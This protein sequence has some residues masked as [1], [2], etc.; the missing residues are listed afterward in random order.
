MCLSKHR[1]KF[2]GR[3][4]RIRTKVLAVINLSGVSKEENCQSE[5]VIFSP[6]RLHEGYSQRVKKTAIYICLHMVFD[7]LPYDSEKLKFSFSRC[8]VWWQ[9]QVPSI[10]RM[11]I[12]KSDICYFGTAH[13]T[14]KI[15]ASTGF[16]HVPAWYIYWLR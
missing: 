9:Q 8:N 12:S 7:R 5:C 1:N 3:I 14:W 13:R 16:K 6:S 15:Q 10:S 11:I 4:Q 2:S